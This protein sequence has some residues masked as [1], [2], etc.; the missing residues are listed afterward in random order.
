MH[1][2]LLGLKH[3]IWAGVLLTKVS[4]VY[5]IYLLAADSL[6]DHLHKNCYHLCEDKPDERAPPTHVQI[7]EQN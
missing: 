7:C 4:L 2:A 6:A 5:C 3:D 1:A